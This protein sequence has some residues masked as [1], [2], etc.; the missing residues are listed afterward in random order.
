M[1]KKKNGINPAAKGA[2]LATIVGVPLVFALVSFG[3]SKLLDIAPLVLIPVCAVAAAVY[4][5][6]TCNLL[7]DYCE[8]RRP[9]FS[10][11]PCYGELAL[12]DSLFLKIG[13]VLY[14]FVV[15]SLV[16]SRLPYTA[17]SF[18]GQNLAVRF[19]FWATF[20]AFVFLFAIQVVKGIGIL[21]CIKMVSDEWTEK[22]SGTVGFIKSFGWLGFI[23][24]VR[25]MAIYGINK[26]LS[27]L[28]TF[29]DITISDTQ[30][31]ELEEE[32]E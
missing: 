15:V 27:T 6:I 5:G 10:F 16:L 25:V 32:D 8:V 21:G 22:M 20:V 13:S 11:I 30:D 12:M 19:P 14:I 31:V 1:A 2:V 9:W 29:N 24:F 28:V 3:T 18:L 7:Y 17:L 23:P 4:N 26:P